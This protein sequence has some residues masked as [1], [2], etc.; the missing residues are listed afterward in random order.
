MLTRSSPSVEQIDGHGVDA[1]GEDEDMVVALPQA[2]FEL[3]S[4]RRLDEAE[5]DELLRSAI[6]RIR[7][8]GEEISIPSSLALESDHA[9]EIPRSIHGLPA[10]DAWVLFVVRMATRGAA[11]AWQSDPPIKGVGP[12]TALEKGLPSPSLRMRQILYD[13]VMEDFA[14]R[15]VRI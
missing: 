14:D 9:S 4:A 5:R 12:S 3:P 2:I 6:G 1:E 13:Y 7:I 15:C 11:A 10:S 8:K